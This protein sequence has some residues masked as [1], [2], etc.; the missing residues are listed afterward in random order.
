LIASVA[1]S[2][3]L[4]AWALLAGDFGSVEAKILLTSLSVSAAS[5]LGMGC[6][7]AWERRRFGLAPHAGLV[8]A[9]VACAGVV[10]GIW[11]E[12]GDE[13]WWKAVASCALAAI[14]L[15]HACL[16]TL[17]RLARSHAWARWAAVGCAAGTAGSAIV[18]PWTEA[19][20]LEWWWRWTGVGAVPRAAFTIAVPIL[21]RLSGLPPER[22][23]EAEL[24]LRVRACPPC[25]AA[26][27]APL[28]EIACV[29]CGGRVRVERL[30]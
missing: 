12:I 24:A 7:V 13:T 21:H 8:L 14:A 30:R 27:D 10:A 17:A 19:V 28:G 20:D 1:L 25:G 16:L 23:A 3:L 15:A 22:A 26:A 9:L 4:G 2:A 6:A 29:A 18:M 11:A 5:I